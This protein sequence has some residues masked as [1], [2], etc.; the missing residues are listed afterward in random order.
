LE[1]FGISSV[2]IVPIRLPGQVIGTLGLT[3]DRNGVPYT[4]EDHL[5][6][7]D[8]ADRAALTIQNAR[9]FQEVSQQRERLGLLS[10]RLAEAQEAERRAVARELHDEIGQL[11]YA[12]SANLEAIRFSPEAHR[13]ASQL[14][15]SAGLVDEAIHQVRD[16]ALELR[17]SMLDDFGLAPAVAW[18]V[19]RQAQRA[20]FQAAFAADPPDLRLPPA[21]E[22]TVYRLVQ[23]AL[24]N[25]ARHAHARQ[26]HVS[27]RRRGAD[28]ELLVS[29]DGTGF[30]VA[31]ARERARQGD[32]LG[33]LSMEERARLA[34]GLLEIESAPGR[35]TQVRAHF[36]VDVGDAP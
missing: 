20:G 31:A 14:A 18:L 23:A 15:E 25:A 28:V 27:I 24:T 11:L 2:L 16:L 12:V 5:F 34:G 17:P 7:Q 10:A 32:T 33:L 1:T 29:D 36:H 4:P 22:T 9:L 19:E 3:R 8:I 30:D 26:V 35:G 6:L 13:T 21:L